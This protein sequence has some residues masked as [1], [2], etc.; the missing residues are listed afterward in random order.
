MWRFI[1]GGTW[2]FQALVVVLALV[3]IQADAAP[4]R[5]KKTEPPP[6]KVEETVGDLAMVL[7]GSEVKVEGVGLVAGLDN[8]GADPPPSWYRSQL[9]DE[10][11]KAGV[12]H[13]SKLLA[14]T[15]Y[16]MV[17][18]KMT[19]NTGSTPQDRFDVEVELPPAS[20]TTS[21]AGGYLLTTRLH[22]VMIAGGAARTGTE[23]AIAQG[24]VM[25]GS[26]KKPN[27]PKVGRVLGGGRVKR[28]SP[29]MLVIKEKRRSVRTAAIIEGVVNERFHPTDS[30][31]QKG[32]A[33]AKTDGYL[34]LRVPPSYHQNQE[35][36][37]RV[38]QLLHMVDTPAL[39]AQRMAVWGKELLDPTTS[40]VAALRLEGLGVSAVET[41]REALKSP[42]PQVRF[43][44]AESLAYLDDAS[45]AEALAE[46]VINQPKFR[47][48][49]LA[50][51]ASSDQNA[52][53]IKL[54][55]LMDQADVEVRYGAFNALRTFDP[56]DPALGQVRVMDEPK[57]E[58][59]EAGDAP[60]SMAIA[61]AK[62]PA[63][64]GWMTRLPSISS[65]RK[66]RRSSM[67]HA[68]A[69]PRSSF[70]AE[71][72]ASC[73]RSCWGRGPSC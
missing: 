4:L 41:L 6:P 70:S 72:R 1:P 52:C 46:T 32:A 66:A 35:R 38:V 18:V 55:H 25:I 54:R 15:R 37:F 49:A 65:I 16:S 9:V 40:G 39:R 69:D 27:D 67:S 5:K 42:N 19:I 45:G 33:T 12:E 62:R 73:P 23:L 68:H 10:M 58:E 34:V 20:G 14:D 22:E 11:S 7:Q 50:A 56:R 64:G 44:A 71:V 53:H 17:I 59:D 43:F 63:N 21:L 13:A 61:L 31:R 48:Y 57:T 60:D 36:F 24:P 26:A 51:L 2:V 47:A 30:G 28:E 3:Q 8:T 29:Y